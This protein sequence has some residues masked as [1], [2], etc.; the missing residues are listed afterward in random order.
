MPR[1]PGF[2]LSNSRRQAALAGRRC[3]QHPRP[4]PVCVS[5]RPLLRPRRR[6]RCGSRR[7]EHGDL[8]DLIHLNRGCTGLTPTLDEARACACQVSGAATPQA[9][10]GPLRTPECHQPRLWAHTNRSPAPSTHTSAPA[11]VGTPH[12]SFHPA[13]W[14][15]PTSAPRQVWPAPPSPNTGYRSPAVAS[16]P[17]LARDGSAPR[18]SPRR[19]LGP[20][21]RRRACGSARPARR[22]GKQLPTLPA[23]GRAVGQSPRRPVPAGPEPPLHQ[24]AR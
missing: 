4:Q 12:L 24:C 8:S 6:V 17:R 14:Y 1:R 2:Y 19:A 9:T 20:P 7:R 5:H 18:R 21:A 11:A 3:P 22:S 10:P 23:I 15:Q 16:A 13:C